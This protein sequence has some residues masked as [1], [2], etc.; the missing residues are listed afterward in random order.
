MELLFKTK[1]RTKLITHAF[2]NPRSSYYVR[3]FSGLLKEDA[4]NLS[5][6]LRRL[7]QEG[8]FRSQS[9]GREKFYVLN[10]SYPFYRE[11]KSIVTKSVRRSQ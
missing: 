10:K 2:T 7:E 6:E 5:R 9:T 8:L 11:F 3:E 4:G 1:L